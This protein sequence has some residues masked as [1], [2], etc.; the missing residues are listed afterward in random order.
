MRRI[1]FYSFCLTAFLTL[2][3]LASCATVM[4]PYE[5]SFGCPKTGNGKCVSI[6]DAY[7]ESLEDASSGY[8][9]SWDRVEAYPETWDTKK[10]EKRQEDDWDDDEWEDE[11]AQQAVV[12]KEVPALNYA[13]A[14][15]SEMTRLLKEPVT[16]MISPPKIMRVLLLPYKGSD[17]EL[18]MY[19]YVYFMVDEPSWIL[20][21][22]LNP[23]KEF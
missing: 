14:L 22:Y 17:K 4:N 3:L 23:G 11:K 5:D 18:F 20:D 15:Y 1:K 12:V 7:Q 2:P 16:P 13:D 8:D 19:R 21:G 9:K 10:T 6:E